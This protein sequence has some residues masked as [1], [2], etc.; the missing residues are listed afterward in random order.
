M[1]AFVGYRVYYIDGNYSDSS[2]LVL[3]HENFIL[4]L[5][6]ANGFQDNSSWL[7]KPDPDPAWTLLYRA[8][9]AY[10]VSTLFPADWN[11]LVRAFLTNDHIFQQFWYFMHKGHVSVPCKDV[12][13]ST[14]I[15]YLR[16]GR[17]DLLERCDLIDG[18]KKPR[19]SSVRKTL[20]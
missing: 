15:C 19:G 8:S 13:K 1:F 4:N 16:S 5:T 18:V 12:C 9:Q 2:R 3:D 10:G 14:L 7:P 20:C 6:L 11:A 17:H